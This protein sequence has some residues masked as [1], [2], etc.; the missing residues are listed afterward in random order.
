MPSYKA[1][2][3]DQ[4]FVLHE[5]LGA[6]DA[7]R[8]MPRYAELDADTVN[9]VIEE[10]GKFCEDQLLPINR[11]GD[12]EGCIYDA[13]SRTGENAARLQGGLRRLSRGRLAGPRSRDRVRRP[14]TAASAADRVLRDAVLD[15]PGLGDVPRTDD[16]CVRVPAEACLR[17]AEGA[18]PAEAR[19]GTV[20]RHDVPDRAALR[21]RSR[22]AAYEGRAATRRQLPAD[23]REDLHFLRR[24]R[25]GGEH[26]APRARAPA[27]R[28]ARDER[29]LALHR[30]EVRAHRNRRERRG[31][32]A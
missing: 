13:A 17:R 23:R 18:F 12:E 4:Q 22:H 20:D 26:R 7:L 5:V 8:Q 16:R 9:Q 10:A 32:R 15:Q 11:S 31:R 3:R 29:N 25:H 28:A 24:A 30:A 14:G 21:H 2:L 19:L 6:V 27:G 1:P